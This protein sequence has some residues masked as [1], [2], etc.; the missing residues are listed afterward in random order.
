[1]SAK[2]EVSI[3][4]PVFNKWQLTLDCLVS[5]KEY[6]PGTHYEVIVVDNASRDATVTQLEPLG[7]ALFGKRFR[8]IRNTENL[9]FGPACNQGARAAS[10]PL[11]FFLNNDTLMTRDWLPPLLAAMREETDLGAVGPLLLY[12][13]DT[14][15]HLG[16]TFFVSGIWHLY[17]QYPKDHPVVR[18]KRDLQAITAAALLISKN[19]FWE[20]GGFYEEYKNGFEDVD[21]CLQIISKG[22]K[23]RCVPDSVIYHLESQTPGRNSNEKHNAKIITDRWQDEIVFDSHIHALRDNLRPMIDD[24]LNVC[25]CPPVQVN[26]ELNKAAKHQSFR[27]IHDQI[28]ANPGWID[29]MDTLRQMAEEYGDSATA[30]FYADMKLSAYV[31]YKDVESLLHLAIMARNED[32]VEYAKHLMQKLRKS[33]TGNPCPLEGVLRHRLRRALDHRD[34]TL[35][36]LLEDKLT[37]V[38]LKAFPEA[39]N[40]RYPKY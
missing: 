24:L 9:N 22:K 14:V 34:K 18:K 32:V 6:T 31:S 26:N 23:L 16:V 8:S 15:Q 39:P 29:G 3:I 35:A 7:R 27:W 28:S 1:M 36:K 19:L 20:C 4:I 10:S 25:F 12:M 11:V 37:E 17:Q 21:L 2:P 5:L 33:L 30:L 38:R 40:P 13:D